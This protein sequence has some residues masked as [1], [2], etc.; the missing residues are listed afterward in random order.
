MLD[1]ERLDPVVLPCDA[2]ARPQLDEGQLVAEPSED[3]PEDPEEVVEPCRSVDRQW[4][5]AAPEREGLQHSRQA[6]VVVGVVVRQEDLGK[7]DEPN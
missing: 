2:L 3:A 4:H 7:L 6:E 1:R 5:L